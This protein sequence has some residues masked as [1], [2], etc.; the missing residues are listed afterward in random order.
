MAPFR[1]APD[2]LAKDVA[3]IGQF[4]FWTMW[5]AF[6]FG[7]VEMAAALGFGAWPI[8]EGSDMGHGIAPDLLPRVGCE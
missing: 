3:H 6:I 4:I 1:P 8:G 5:I 7:G 2:T